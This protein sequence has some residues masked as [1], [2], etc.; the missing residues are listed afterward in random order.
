MATP[1]SD[2]FIAQIRGAA[3]IMGGVQVDAI[4]D[5]A[6]AVKP[7]M[8][9]AVSSMVGSDG[10]LRNNTNKAGRPKGG[11]KVRYQIRQSDAW[12]AYARFSAS[13][14]IALIEKGAPPHDIAPRRKRSRRNRSRA[15]AMQGGGYD[16]PV[17]KPIHHPGFRGKG[18]WAR[19]RDNEVPPAART[20]FLSR[21][22]T[23]FRKAF[24]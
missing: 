21:N 20:A 2:A 1:V 7:I 18:R 19:A 5:A 23:A 13:G 10:Q 16:H 24:T 8:E 11:I 3:S 4:T 12:G 6:K 9:G 15:A 22:V 14:P 17:A